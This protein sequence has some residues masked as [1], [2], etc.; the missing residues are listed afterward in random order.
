M[1]AFATVEDYEARQGALAEGDRA[2]CGALLSDA[3]AAMRSRFRAFHGRAWEQGVNESF[4]E[5]AA[6]VCTA[7]VARAMSVPEA[8]SGV[9]QY[10]QTAGSYSASAT[11]SNPSGDLYLTKGDL[12]ALGLVGTRVGSIAAMTAAD[13]EGAAS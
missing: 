6:A 2:R 5:N 10:S 9:T 3:S 7:V 8:L 11:Y 13:R 1:E 4:D 12:R